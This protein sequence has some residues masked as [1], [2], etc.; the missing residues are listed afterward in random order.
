MGFD[1]RTVGKIPP[2]GGSD[3]LYIG[4]GRDQYNHKYKGDM[5]EIILYNRSLTEKET[6]IIQKVLKR[7]W[8][9]K[10]GFRENLELKK[11]IQKWLLI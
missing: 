1:K 8:S 6:N 7:K 10:N 2:E 11:F 4:K 3:K 5:G 9:F